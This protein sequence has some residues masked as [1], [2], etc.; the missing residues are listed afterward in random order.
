VDAAVRHRGHHRERLRRAQPD[1]QLGAQ[2]RL[3]GVPQL[4]LEAH[5]VGEQGGQ[6]GHREPGR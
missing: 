3:D 5:E 6:V 1:A 4:D 2:P